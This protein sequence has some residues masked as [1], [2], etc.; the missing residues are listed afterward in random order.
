AEFTARSIACGF[1]S[2]Q[3]L[4]VR[5]LRIRSGSGSFATGRDQAGTI[6]V[7]RDGAQG[8]AGSLRRSRDFIAHMQ[9]SLGGR[10]T[11]QLEQNIRVLDVTAVRVSARNA[12]GYDQ[13][14]IWNRG[15]SLCDIPLP[16]DRPLRRLA[17]E[18]AVIGFIGDGDIEERIGAF[19]R[20]GFK[21]VD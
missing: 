3:L 21:T 15:C 2:D 20:S 14:L 1:N 13:N 7:F 4:A 17:P 12:R 6:Y 10:G 5:A 16:L 18:V 8:I 11:G 9:R 19:Q